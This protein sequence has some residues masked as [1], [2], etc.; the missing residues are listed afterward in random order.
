MERKN[1]LR[2]FAVAAVSG[3]V[4]FDACK[5]DSSVIP[6]TSTTTTS[7]STGTTTTTGSCVTTP[8]EE[9]GPYP[10]PG[11]EIKNPLNRID[12]LGG[13]TGVSHQPSHAGQAACRQVRAPCPWRRRALRLRRS[14]QLPLPL[15]WHST[16]ILDLP[17]ATTGATH[18]R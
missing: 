8:T 13:Q 16:G 9:E 12:I 3:P 17:A 1:F 11:G 14:G 15:R 2:T 5:K 18:R 7:T 10:Y 6:S 4:L